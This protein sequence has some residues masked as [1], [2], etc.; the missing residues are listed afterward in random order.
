MKNA[1]TTP[2]TTPKTRG[3]ENNCVFICISKA[4][5]DA[6]LVTTIPEAVAI[7]SAGI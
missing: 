6:L 3:F 2:A 4:V 1:I 7:K 5:P